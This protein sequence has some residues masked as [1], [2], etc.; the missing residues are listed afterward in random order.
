MDQ[1]ILDAPFDDKFN[2]LEEGETILWQS[3]AR[4]KGKNLIQKKAYNPLKEFGLQDLV[5]LILLPIICVYVLSYSLILFII[6][7]LSYSLM[8]FIIHRMVKRN[9]QKKEKLEY[10]IT[11]E[12]IIY[13]YP[14]D[15]KSEIFAIDRSNIINIKLQKHTTHSSI[16]FEVNNNPTSEILTRRFINGKS[17]IVGKLENIENAE[18]AFRLLKST[19]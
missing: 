15:R 12:R 17:R 4:K 19:K 6:A 5:Y 10:Y 7:T 1:Q 18:E 2:F 3:G 14:S 16:N 9:L 11:Q 8:L 13:L